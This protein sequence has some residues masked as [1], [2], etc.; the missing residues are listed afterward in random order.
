VAES[1]NRGASARRYRAKAEELR[2]NI[3]KHL[4]DEKRGYYIR[5]FADSGERV[6]FNDAIVQGWAI[7]SGAARPDRP[8]RAMK[9]AVK[10]LYKK[11]HNMILLF[12]QLLQDQSWGGSL[13]AYPDGIRENRAQY[14]HGA[15]MMVA[16]YYEQVRADLAQAEKLS[17]ARSNQKNR[18]L[19]RA[20]SKEQKRQ[21]QQ[22]DELREE[23]K[24]ASALLSALLPSGHASDPKYGGEPWAVTSGV[25]GGQR[26]GESDW[27]WYTGSAGWVY[28][29]G[30][31]QRLGLKF[32]AGNRLVIDPIIP[33]DWPGFE[34]TYRKGRS[35]YTIKVRNPDRVAGGVARV[36][37]D[38]AEQRAPARGVLLADDGK[39]HTIEVT[40]G[41]RRAQP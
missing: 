35:V 34:A 1:K 18:K 27:T 31:E 9:A 19:P 2:G 17:A 41:R 21:R 36:T 37:L 16:G 22:V 23:I 30:I 40:M 10:A 26:A 7:L 6:D 25:Y 33:A 3:E 32:Q 14:T 8:R 15:A 11:D 24:M 5:G 29:I 20:A 13:R 38:G 39:Q 28:R 4:W 12:D